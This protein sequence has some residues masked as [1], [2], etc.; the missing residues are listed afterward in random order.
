LCSFGPP[1]VVIRY[2]YVNQYQ[3]AR[4]TSRFPRQTLNSGVNPIHGTGQADSGTVGSRT[5]SM[6]LQVDMKAMRQDLRTM[7]TEQVRL[8]GKVENTMRSNGR[9]IYA[10][11]FILTFV[12]TVALLIF[13]IGFV[14]VATHWCNR[15]APIRHLLMTIELISSFGPLYTLQLLKTGHVFFCSNF[16]KCLRM[17]NHCPK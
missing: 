6:V 17:K 8:R 14:M 16:V 1:V 10:F 11:F 13:S 3:F 15:S 2:R 5:V 7:K 4:L 9:G 12:M